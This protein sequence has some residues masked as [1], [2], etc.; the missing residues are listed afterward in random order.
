M[1]GVTKKTKIN[2]DLQFMLSDMSMAACNWVH[3][4]FKNKLMEV[5]FFSFPATTSKFGVLCTIE[6]IHGWNIDI[7]YSLPPD[8]RCWLEVRYSTNEFDASVDH[9][10]NPHALTEMGQR[11]FGNRQM[12]SERAMWYGMALQ[13]YTLSTVYHCAVERHKVSED[14]VHPDV[15]LD[16]WAQIKL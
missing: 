6:F 7:F 8:G 14:S 3:D 4:L 11:F 2:V 15:V 10:L 9:R 12:N 1:E 16:L 13:T 5:K